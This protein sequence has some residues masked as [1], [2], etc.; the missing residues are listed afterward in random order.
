MLMKKHRTSL[1]QRRCRQTIMLIT[2]SSIRLPA[3]SRTSVQRS[4]QSLT[5][6]IHLAD[7]RLIASK[8]MP[9]SRGTKQ[10]RGLVCTVSAFTTASDSEPEDNQ[11]A[12]AAAPNS[13]SE[14]PAYP[15]DFVR[16]RL[17]TFISIVLG[18]SCFY[19]TR[20]S[21]TYTAPVMVADKT[22]GFTITDVSFALYLL[23]SSA[24]NYMV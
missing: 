24:I 15:K 8:M 14:L 10:H 6:R 17:V 22:L 23:C 7:R 2:S 3:I 13:L 9:S 12:A 11:T 4:C 21:L 20:N 18:Y 16:R 5:G 1:D 19:L